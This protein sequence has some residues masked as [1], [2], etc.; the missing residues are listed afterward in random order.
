MLRGGEDFD[1]DDR[2]TISSLA[3]VPVSYRRNH[4]NAGS[5]KMIAAKIPHNNDVAAAAN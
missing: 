3:T 5:S 1:F 4:V 2:S